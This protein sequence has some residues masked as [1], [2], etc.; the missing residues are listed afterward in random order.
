MN[1]NKNI[2][3]EIVERYMNLKIG[4]KKIKCPYFINK[5]RKKDLRVMVGKGDPD[6]IETETK[7]WAKI[8]NF[9]LN[10][11]DN[12]Q[13]REFMTNMGIGIDCS[14]FVV[15]VLNMYFK[16]IIGKSIWKYF[17]LPKEYGLFLKIG[18]LLR[19]AEKLGAD[20]LTNE[21]NCYI[22]NRIKDIQVLDLIR[23]KSKVQNGHHVMI[24]TD[25]KFRESDN[26][27]QYIEYAHSTPYFDE[28]NGVK[29][30]RITIRNEDLKLEDQ[31]WEEIDSEGSCPTLDGYLKN[32]EDNGIRRPKFYY[33]LSKR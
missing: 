8:K 23:S 3:K 27:L 26:K 18:Y 9:N 16:S 33:Q 21:D 12:K 13:I 4:G 19:P 10:T 17:S 22:V 14:G 7:L 2:L 11:A 15:H 25:L 31:I 32:V 6:E 24:V 29:Y 20:I 1:I 5:Y 30:G 28:D